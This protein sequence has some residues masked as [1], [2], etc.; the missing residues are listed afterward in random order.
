[1]AALN[2]N[3]AASCC[4]PTSFRVAASEIAS[5]PAFLAGPLAV[6][7]ADVF[8]V[9][10]AERL[11]PVGLRTPDAARDTG[12]L[13]LAMLEISVD[14]PPLRTERGNPHAQW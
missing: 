10:F 8:A 1:L 2:G 11:L 7:R 12:R 3:S 6:E 5:R 9:S 13:L 14:R 4:V